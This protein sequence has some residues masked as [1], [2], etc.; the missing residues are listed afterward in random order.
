MR[1]VLPLSLLAV[2]AG[3]TACA[4]GEERN[5]WPVLVEQNDAA[6]AAP[7]WTAAGPLLFSQPVEPSRFNGATTASGFRP[8]YLSA[9]TEGGQVRDGYGLYPLFSYHRMEDGYRWS[10]FSLV[11]HYSTTASRDSATQQG[12]D[13]WPLYFSRD[14]GNPETSYHAVLPLYGDVKQRFGQDRLTWVLFPLYARWEKN[15]VRTFTAPWPFLKIMTGEDNHGFDLWPLFGHREKAGVYRDQF[16]LWPL[17]YDREVALPEGATDHR[18]GFLPFYAMAR[19]PDFRS[20]TFLWPFF[21][22]TDRTAPHVYHQTDYFWPLF[23][24]G[25]GQDRLVNRWAPFHTHSVIKGTDKRWILWPLWREEK[26]SDGRLAHRKR[27][28]LYFLYNDNR[29]RSVSNPAL[30]MARKTH[31]WPFLT[32]WDNGAGQ[33]QVQALSPLEVFFPDND[34]VRLLYSP[35]FAL[36]R[37]NR[38]APGRVEHFAL[39]HFLSYRRSPSHREFHLGP[40]YSQESGGGEKRFALGNGLIALQRGGGRGWHFSFL[41]FK[42]RS[43]APRPPAAHVND[44]E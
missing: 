34:P 40:L 21:G 9:T 13:L 22:Y 5:I 37:Y 28:L 16:Y 18:A 10:F 24:Q 12:F 20:E 2:L 31:Y 27:Q 23:V 14:T 32:V 42:R 19:T 15:R 26:W 36:Y 7:R 6:L 1:L 44:H 41:D 39:W 4:G 25:R 17:I 38:P 43:S 8:F 11:N 35:L 29:Q 30:P 33:K 3:A